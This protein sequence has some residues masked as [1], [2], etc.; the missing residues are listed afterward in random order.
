MIKKGSVTIK[1][2]AAEL[3]ISPSTVSRALADNPLVKPATRKAVKEL[4][5]KYNYQ[6]NFTALSLRS[7]KTRTLGIIIPQLVHE[8]FALVIRGIEDYAYSNGYNVI[9][10]STHENYERE[11]IDAKALLTGRVDGLLACIS[12]TTDNYDHFKEFEKRNIPLVF[13][14]C[15]CDEIDTFKVV[16]D[17]KHAAYVATRHLIEKGAK[18]IAYVGGP[19]NL[20]IN[21]DR[22]EGYQ[23][24]L[25]EF[26][27]EFDQE[28]VVHCETGNYDDGKKASAQLLGIQKIDGVFAGTDMLAV[29]A[30]KNLKANGRNVPAD[31]KVVGFSN[32]SISELFEPSISTVNQPGYEMGSKAAELLIAQIN[33]PENK[34]FTTEILQT[35]LIERESSR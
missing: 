4:A 12:R 3:N 15:I 7:N 31:V 6:P 17:D 33:N 19:K 23:K 8:F 1:D 32:W 22:Y 25:K 26:N 35:D 14:D 18:N 20:L 11:V 30:I 2:I 16:I 34:N 29:A 27:I 28:L 13:F 10:C 21:K 9:I 24:A 5:E